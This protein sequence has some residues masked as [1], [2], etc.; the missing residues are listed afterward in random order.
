MLGRRFPTI[1][2]IGG[3]LADVPH[4]GYL[5]PLTAAFADPAV[6]TTLGGVRSGDAAASFIA[7]ARA[8]WRDAGFG[9][10][11][12]RGMADGAFAGWAGVR[13]CEVAGEPTVELAYAL[14]P[15][16][17]CKGHATRIGRTALALGFENLGLAE[18]VAFTTDSNLHSIAVIERL[19]FAYDRQFDHAGLRHALY[20][21]TAAMHRAG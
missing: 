12:L 13:R 15:A 21:R 2:E 8:H 20:R 3:V 4:D 10:W 1:L 19:A 16:M 18:I 14:M 7:R 17:R 6:M 9:I 5:A 11:F